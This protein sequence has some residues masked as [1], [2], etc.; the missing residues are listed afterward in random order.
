[1]ETPK[2]VS[3]IPQIFIEDLRF[4]LETPLFLLETPDFRW[5][6]PYFRWRPQDFHLRPADFRPQI[7]V[8]DRFALKTPDF[9]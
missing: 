3:W 2:D 5:R 9:R 7:F 1:M 8:R 6:S 4:S